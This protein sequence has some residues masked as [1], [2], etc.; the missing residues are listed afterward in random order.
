MLLFLMH[1]MTA[2][3]VNFRVQ[4]ELVE[5]VIRQSHV[6]TVSRLK[7]WWKLHSNIIQ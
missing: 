7:L 3:V 2:L 4:F 1:A 6:S 5:N